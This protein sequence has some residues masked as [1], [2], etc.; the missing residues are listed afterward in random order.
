MDIEKERRA[1]LI[2]GLG[3]H[4]ACYEHVRLRHPIFQRFTLECDVLAVPR[5]AAWRGLTFAFEVKLPEAKML[6]QPKF[7]TR[8]IKQASDYVY[9]EV[10]APSHSGLNGR[11]VSAAFL[12]PGPAELVL[13][14]GLL[15][16]TRDELRGVFEVANHF[17]VGRAN[18]VPVGRN[19]QGRMSIEMGVNIWRSDM[20]FKQTAQ[21]VLRG[22]R[23]F[24]SQQVDLLAELS[25]VD[26]QAQP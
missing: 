3:E 10:V 25:G 16:P 7:W 13:N 24:G 21:G 4:F 8:A 11:R 5:D 9:S 14:A 12:F 17:R 2:A 6:L 18:W 20:G 1:E 19:P 23:P 15:G 22:R 26:V